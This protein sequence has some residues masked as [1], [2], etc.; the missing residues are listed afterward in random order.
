MKEQKREK[1]EV[2]AASK[3]FLFRRR[4]ADLVRSGGAD[5]QD[6]IK[7]FVFC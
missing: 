5:L 1:R 4:D 3:S 7:L 2:S 6:Y